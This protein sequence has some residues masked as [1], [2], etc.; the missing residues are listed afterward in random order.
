M[1]LFAYRGIVHIT[2]KLKGTL[3]IFRRLNPDI[4]ISHK[5]PSA[6]QKNFMK[7]KES[8]DDST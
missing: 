6:N 4:F 8:E 1:L 2:N 5:C 3:Q 7:L